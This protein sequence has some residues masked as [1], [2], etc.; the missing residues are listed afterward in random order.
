MN[1]K[2]YFFIYTA[3]SFFEEGGDYFCD[4]ETTG[5]NTSVLRNSRINPI[6]P[7]PRSAVEGTRTE[8]IRG[9]NSRKITEISPR[10]MYRA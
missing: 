5:S 1:E 3:P 10:M 4:V 2:N 7:V 9:A 6:L 8:N